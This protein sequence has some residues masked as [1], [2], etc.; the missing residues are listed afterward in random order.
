MEVIRR[1]TDYALRLVTL[2]ARRQGEEQ[3]VSS[4]VLAEEAQVPYTLTCKLLQKLQKK[5]IVKSVMGP[6]GGFLLAQPPEQVSFLEVVELVQGPIRMNRCLL[7]DHVCPLKQGCPLH[8]QMA[9]LQKEVREHLGATTFADV[10]KET[11]TQ[12]EGESHE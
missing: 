1:N 11:E 6:K 12:K 10:I 8:G 9:G 4:R 7:G 3:K 5:G 2:L